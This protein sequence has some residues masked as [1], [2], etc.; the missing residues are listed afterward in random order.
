MDTVVS[1]SFAPFTTLG[2]EASRVMTGLMMSRSHQEQT[3]RVAAPAGTGVTG[4]LHTG[5]E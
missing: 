1:S 2:R 5:Q 3:I 4:E